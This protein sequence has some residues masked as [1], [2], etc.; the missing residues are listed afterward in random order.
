[1]N[2]LLFPL[3]A[4]LLPFTSGF[5]LLTRFAPNLP[6]QDDYRAILEFSLTLRSLPDVPSRLLYLVGAQHVDYKLIFEHSVVALQLAST[7]HLNFRAL[8]IAGDFF[9]PAIFL[10]V[11]WLNAAYLSKGSP[12]FL[13]FLPG[14]FLLCSLNYVE[15]LNWA[16][17]GLQNLPVIFFA[18][19]SIFALAGRGITSLRRFTVACLLAV[20]ACTSSAN[21]FLLAPV[22]LFYLVRGHA[23][24]RSF[25]WCLAFVLPL[26]AY[27]YRYT[28]VHP[29]SPVPWFTKP[30]F[31]LA[32]LG[33][34][35]PQKPGV[36]LGAIIFGVLIW[37]FRSGFYRT[38]PGAALASLWIVLTAVLIAIGR[39]NYGLEAS[40]A[41]RYKLYPD[42][43]LVLL[44]LYVAARVR[45][46]SIPASRKKQLFLLVLASSILFCARADYSAFKMLRARDADL[47][48]GLAQFRQDPSR[49]SP[50]YIGDPRAEL[51]QAE[52]DEAARRIMLLSMQ[53]GL[54]TPPV[55]P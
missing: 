2:L 55:R 34:A 40:Q 4:A 37:A 35:F 49:F 33:S 24:R 1:M 43:L 18:L 23:V 39:G 47:G 27:L 29:T 17:A 20:L 12:R 13:M 44:Y 51:I 9:L 52:E 36:V 38:N 22:G 26:T 21:G 45:S 41:S 50:M 5:W 42:I 46:S 31:V 53:T 7:H 11:W 8:I 6:C 15:T 14:A 28:P 19:A 54:Y 3:L 10:M 32:L 48:I 30:L 25:V 16:M